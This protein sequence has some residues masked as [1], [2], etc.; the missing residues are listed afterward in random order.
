[1]SEPPGAR[2]KLLDSTTEAL[3]YQ[4]HW[5]EKLKERVR[6]GEPLALVN[7]DCPQE[8]FRA[9]EIPYVVNQ[10]WASVVTAKQQAD[11]YLKILTDRGYPDDSEQYSAISIA[12]ALEGLSPEAPWGGLPRPSILVGELS[13]DAARKVFDILDADP[14][15]TF[16]PLEATVSDVVPLNWWELMPTQW[17]RVIGTARIELMVEQMRG[18]IFHLETVTGR[19]LRRRRLRDV[20]RLVNEQ[21][22]WSRKARDLI[23]GTSPAP[24]RVDDSIPSVMIPQWHRGTEWARD[25]ARTFYSEVAERVADGAAVCADERRRLMW[26]GRGLWFDMD[27][28]RAFEVSHGAVFVWSMY[29]AIAADGYV[30]YGDD[31]LRALAGRFASFSD[32]LY[33]PPWSSEWYVKEAR[34][35]KVD[36]VVHLVSD[37]HRGSWFVNEAL[38]RAGIPVLE[39]R[40]DNV[41]QRGYD[42]AAVRSS[43]EH[44]LEHEVPEGAPR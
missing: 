20:M 42:R 29:L 38:R 33:M 6:Q 10:W 31:P 28:Y 18:L 15:V 36:G 27:L 24:L 44:W 21:E 5:Y 4:R 14:D 1:V 2:P 41:D 34:L 3:R 39:L 30:R 12:S 19:P 13:N 16:F 23:A 35:H 32:Q 9:M 7:A 40:T 37:D 43:I 8:I 25:A 11:R 22:V 17:E 26:I